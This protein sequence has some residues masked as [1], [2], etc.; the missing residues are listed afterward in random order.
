MRIE[1]VVHAEGSACRHRW[2]RSYIRGQRLDRVTSWAGSG[3]GGTR[4]SSVVV[5]RADGVV[6]ASSVSRRRGSAIRYRRGWVPSPVD[7]CPATGWISACGRSDGAPFG[8]LLY[9]R[10]SVS[11]RLGT[12]KDKRKIGRMLFPLH[13]N[14]AISPSVTSKVFVR[15]ELRPFRTRRV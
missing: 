8:G 2:F 5:K 1:Q 13:R 11:A 9:S 3:C 14:L 6:A 15:L 4:S 10:L 7:K 12:T